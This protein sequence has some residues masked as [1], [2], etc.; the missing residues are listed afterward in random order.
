MKV[1]T[2][3]TLSNLKHFSTSSILAIGNKRIV[4]CHRCFGHGVNPSINPLCRFGCVYIVAP[5]TLLTRTERFKGVNKTFTGKPP[6]PRKLTSNNDPTSAG[7]WKWDA[8]LSI[9]ITLL[10]LLG[11]ILTVFIYFRRKKINTRVTF[12]EENFGNTSV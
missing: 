9:P 6:L 8:E 10:C 3:K 2:G 4:P 1:I 12:S 7:E 11:I 5:P